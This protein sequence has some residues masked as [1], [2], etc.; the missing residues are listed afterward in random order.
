M[1]SIS[2]SY[3]NIAINGM[4]DQCANAGDADM[5]HDVN[6][7]P[8][9]DN[10]TQETGPQNSKFTSFI[11]NIRNFTA[12][13]LAVDLADNIG[14]G[15]W[16]RGLATLSGFLALCIALTPD[17]GPIYG[18]QAAQLNEDEFDQLRTQ[19]IVPIA[20]GSDSGIKMASRDN[21]RAL[22]SSPERPTITLSATM[23]R[24]DSFAR[25]LQRAGVSAQDIGAVSN[26]VSSA[27]ALGDIPSG[28]A[29][30]IMLGR[31]TSKNSPRPL[32]T[33]S[34]RARFD[35][36][37]SV[38]R[39]NGALSLSRDSILV[40]NTP[41]RIRGTVGNSLFRSARAAGAPA[42]AVQKFLRVIDAQMSVDS[43]RSGDEFDIIIDYKR[44]ETGEVEVGDLLYAG[45]D[46]G[47]RPKVQMLKWQSGS[48]TQWFEAS[49]VG[50]SRGE[51]GRPV[52]GRISSGYGMRRHPILGYR[53]MHAGIDFA[54]PHGTPIYAVTSGTVRY[55]G[56]K[57][58]NG[59]YVQIDHGSG[60]ATG[61]SH[62]SRIAARS[63]QNVRR[64]QIIG[65]VGSTGL[66]TGAH[67]HYTLYKNGR[68]VNPMSVKFT[69]KAQLSG[70]E[71][72]RFR[73]KLNALKS[74]SPGA[75][76]SPLKA[77]KTEA[78]ANL[79]EIDRVSAV[80]PAQHLGRTTTKAQFNI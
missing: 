61:Y 58:G 17:F 10:E 56:R 2:S 34:F 4:D 30:Q 39:T 79:R 59:N 40:D 50:E 78:D 71:L 28:T 46:R 27:V 73:G 5:A 37:L 12:D 66:S 43:I 62:L 35:L 9:P 45:I 11:N 72:A 44:A 63:G 54:A 33:L 75:A 25:V 23:G 1:K 68:T 26:L 21:V 18:A 51:F 65:Y 19:M 48:S 41:L 64:G 55:S 29:L 69:T 20:Y 36:N 49:G 14:S 13:D 3:D 53:R 15:K 57:G 16:F 24:G 7:A 52:N 42:D 74:V 47:G 6:I 80:T 8:I 77:R 67:L 32:E 76:L 70:A 22:S 31:R 60:L 38:A